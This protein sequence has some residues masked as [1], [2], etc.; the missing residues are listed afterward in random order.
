VSTKRVIV[1]FFKRFWE[2]FFLLLMRVQS[3]LPNLTRGRK[4]VLVPR[5]NVCLEKVGR[6]VNYYV[7]CIWK[8]SKS[9]IFFFGL[10]F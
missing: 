4:L 8:Q 5:N 6:T 9:F 2:F 10:R 3:G 7:C 1:R